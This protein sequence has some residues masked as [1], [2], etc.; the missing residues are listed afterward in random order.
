MRHMRHDE[1][2][3]AI[4]LVDSMNVWQIMAVSPTIDKKLSPFKFHFWPQSSLD[5]FGGHKTYYNTELLVVMFAQLFHCYHITISIGN[6][7]CNFKLLLE[8]LYF[9][10]I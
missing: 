6:I 8:F 4:G 1:H 10:R 2:L 9:L 5:I 3:W 7:P